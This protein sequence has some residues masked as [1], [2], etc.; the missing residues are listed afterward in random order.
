M[1]TLFHN[2]HKIEVH[3]WGTKKVFYDNKL[4]TS[5]DSIFGGTL[6]FQIEED[7]DIATYEVKIFNSPFSNSSFFKFL[8]KFKFRI[9]Y[10]FIISPAVEIRRNGVLLYSD[11]QGDKPEDEQGNK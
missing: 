5:K 9:F 2:G 1:K 4:M 3:C 11:R 6:S 10:P 7:N 8:D